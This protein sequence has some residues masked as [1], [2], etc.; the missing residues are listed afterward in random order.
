MTDVPDSEKLAR[1]VFESKKF[2]RNPPRIKHKA[3]HPDPIDMGT[4]VSRIDG[5]DETTIWEIGDQAGERRQKRALA[6]GEF[7]AS[8]VKR[9]DLNVI[10]DEPPPRHALIIGWSTDKSE[11]MSKA[12]ELAAQA[13]PVIRP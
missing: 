3:F 13:T 5:L 11:Q 9:I 4:S 6:R 8:S 2:T 12:Q 1:F 10:V 7:L